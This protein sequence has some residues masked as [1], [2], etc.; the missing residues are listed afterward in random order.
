M[1]RNATVERVTAR[2]VD[3]M[4]KTPPRREPR[5]A[6]EIDELGRLIFRARMKI[7]RGASQ[8]SRAERNRAAKWAWKF[9][10]EWGFFLR[11]AFHGPRPKGPPKSPWEVSAQ[12]SFVP[13]WGR[14]SRNGAEPRVSASG[15]SPVATTLA[16]RGPNSLPPSGSETP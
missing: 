11:A 5:P 14:V 3:D 10:R 9:R 12:H 6:V 4:L 15:D 16:D 2:I 8:M 7:P 1:M 13:F